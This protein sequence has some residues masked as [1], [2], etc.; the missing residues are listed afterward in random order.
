MANDSGADVFVR[1]QTA[2]LGR[3]DSRPTLAAI[4]CPTVVL[5]GDSDQPTPPARA[6]EIAEGITGATLVTLAQCGHMSA[7]ERPAEVTEALVVWMQA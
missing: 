7:I 2:I 4:A 3:P 6:R 1:Q 5:V